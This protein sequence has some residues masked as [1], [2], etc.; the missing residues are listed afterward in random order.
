MDLDRARVIFW[1]EFNLFKDQKG[2]ISIFNEVIKPRKDMTHAAEV[3]AR[4]GLRLVIGITE[5]HARC[6]LHFTGFDLDEVYSILKKNQERISK[7][8]VG[9]RRPGIKI[10][11]NESSIVLFFYDYGYHFPP[12]NMKEKEALMEW[13]YQNS[14]VMNGIPSVIG[15]KTIHQ[16]MKREVDSHQSSALNVTAP[17]NQSLELN[18]KNHSDLE[19]KIYACKDMCKQPKDQM[20]LGR[21]M[22]GKP[23]KIDLML[24][25]L[26]PN[27]SYT[28]KGMKRS[29]FGEYGLS[30]KRV[31]KLLSSIQRKK[32]AFTCWGTNAIKCDHEKKNEK[33]TILRCRKYLFQEIEIINPKV[34]V[35]FGAPLSNI[36]LNK[37]LAHGRVNTLL[38][39]YI[40][41]QSVHP[42]SRTD[43]KRFDEKNIDILSNVI[44]KYLL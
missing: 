4:G 29:V 10:K 43:K 22:F 41:I 9:K 33:A 39:K 15:M 36:F 1:N 32:G 16:Q 23:G 6:S 25:G 34:I 8:F 27:I 11:K 7:L 14:I 13:M 5:K 28:N 31:G 2:N 18:S 38:N 40:C 37:P 17:I 3:Y 24:I 21:L 35:L 44:V 19:K 30:G 26:G 42:A 12:A 20:L